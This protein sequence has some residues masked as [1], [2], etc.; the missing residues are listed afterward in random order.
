[1]SKRQRRPRGHIEERGAGR[2]RLWVPLGP[3]PDG[4]YRHHKVSFRGTHEEAQTRLDTLLALMGTGH[5]NADG[6]LTYERH[7]REWF[8]DVVKTK[9]ELLT[10][11]EYER[12]IDKRI[13]PRLG[14]IQLNK[15][16]PAHLQ[17]FYADLQRDD[18]R[19]DG[20]PGGLSVA[21]I[22]KLHAVISGSLRHAV[23]MNRITQNPAA[24]VTLPK[25]RRP[26]KRLWTD[27]QLWTFMRVVRHSPHRGLIVMLAYTGM[28]LGEAL[29]LRER[30][31]DFTTGTIHVAEGL[32]RSGPNSVFGPVKNHQER[33][34]PMD[35]ELERV[36]KQHLSALHQTKLA[37][38]PK[39]NSWGVVFPN[40]NGHPMSGDNF[41]KRVWVKLIEEAGLPYINIHGLRHTFATITAK[42]TD[43]ATLRDLLGHESA[44]FTMDEYVHPDDADKRRA[45]SGF[46]RQVRQKRPKGI[47]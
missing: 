7:L 37:M 41:R 21:S 13:V 20:K 45:V 5:I 26:K 43:A 23:K 35:E 1:M 40:H 39:W 38:G 12:L 34:I 10:S 27:E 31:L 14:K 15:L 36:L 29:A 3:G 2:Y 42:I 19:Q 33:P 11:E 24:S 30:N 25:A 16:Q 44:S 32:K 9:N 17:Q 28:R 8:R 46:S 47:V 4:K 22:R 6:E 18:A